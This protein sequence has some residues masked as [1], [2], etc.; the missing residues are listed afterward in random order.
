MPAP[1]E[2]RERWFKQN[3]EIMRDEISE[4][5]Q[6]DPNDWSG[7]EHSRQRFAEKKSQELLE[8]DRQTY[9]FLNCYICCYA[10]VLV[11]LR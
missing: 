4:L 8:K 5:K 6:M 10:P 3:L 2:E 9:L 1:Y 7:I 11:A